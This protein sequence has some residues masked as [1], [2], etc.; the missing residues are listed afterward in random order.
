MECSEANTIRTPS[1]VES[2]DLE[3][4]QTLSQNNPRGVAGQ[5]RAVRLSGS[6]PGSPS[7]Q[8]GPSPYVIRRLTF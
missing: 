5:S 8:N 4:I 6:W 7:P 1:I 2:L 3:G